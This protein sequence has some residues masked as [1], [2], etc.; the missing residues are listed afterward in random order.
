MFGLAVAGACAVGAAGAAGATA[1]TLTLVT[2]AG[3]V[4]P[5]SGYVSLVAATPLTFETSYG[6]VEC[7]DNRPEIYGPLADNESSKPLTVTGLGE[8][9]PGTD[10]GCEAPD[11]LGGTETHHFGELF[12]PYREKMPFEFTSKGKFMIKSPTKGAKVSLV[13]EGAYDE[14]ALC[15]YTAGK[16]AG[17]FNIGGRLVVET[18]RTVFRGVKGQTGPCASSLT[19]A[20]ETWNVDAAD[21]NESTGYVYEPA[22]A[23]S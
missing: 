19:L 4:Q 18:N 10:E 15:T 20:P 16:V 11:Q 13:T 1:A 21:F 6:K 7:G 23:R 12:F 22:E 17:T 3:P 2:G 9:D 5:E 8:F 14:S